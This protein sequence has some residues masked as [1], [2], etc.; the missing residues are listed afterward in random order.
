MER[1]LKTNTVKIDSAKA[2]I[3]DKLISLIVGTEMPKEKMINS[4]SHL[5]G[6]LRHY[7]CNPYNQVCWFVVGLGVFFGLVLLP[8]P[9]IHMVFK[10]KKKKSL[11][12]KVPVWVS[13]HSFYF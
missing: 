7:L 5:V 13:V 9:V 4:R 2:Q 8:L 12:E 11:S 1:H 3:L 10:K 6:Y